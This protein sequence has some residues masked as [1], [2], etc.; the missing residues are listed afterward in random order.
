MCRSIFG[1]CQGAAQRKTR[2]LGETILPFFSTTSWDTMCGAGHANPNYYGAFCRLPLPRF[3]PLANASFACRGFV[4]PGAAVSIFDLLQ[5]KE[6]SGRKP[7]AGPL[8]ESIVIHRSVPSTR[9]LL[10]ALIAY[11][12]SS[13]V[14]DNIRTA[15]SAV[16]Q[17]S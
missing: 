5:H 3:W 1:V 6:Q 4:S 2:N 15:L 16:R 12:G 13:Y 10:T 8:P 14:S 17:G 7:E 11:S 9:E